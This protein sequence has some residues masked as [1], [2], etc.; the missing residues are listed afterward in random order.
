MLRL[1]FY[2]YVLLKYNNIIQ[3]NY[4]F[5]DAKYNQNKQFSCKTNELLR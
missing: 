3:P 1:H 2:L 4:K 5:L